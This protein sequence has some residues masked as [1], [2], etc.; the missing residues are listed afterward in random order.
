MRPTAPPGANATT[1]TL[2][3][4][5]VV[6]RHSE[7]MNITFCDGHVKWMK[8]DALYKNPNDMF[9]HTSM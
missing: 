2:N 7:G 3:G 6:P 1:T 5:P 9:G 8:Q 4:F